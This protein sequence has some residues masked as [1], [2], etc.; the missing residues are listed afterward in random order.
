[1]TAYIGCSAKLTPAARLLVVTC[2]SLTQIRDAAK[3]VR[4][5]AGQEQ[6]ELLRNGARTSEFNVRALNVSLKYLRGQK[7]TLEV[8]RNGGLL[9]TSGLEL[10]P[11]LGNLREGGARRTEA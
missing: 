10:H 7:L 5:C 8:R 3:M 4:V 6:H 2:F 11:L 1:M 9:E